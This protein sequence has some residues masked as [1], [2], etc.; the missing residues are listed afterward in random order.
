[1]EAGAAS[2]AATPLPTIDMSTAVPAQVTS[3]LLGRDQMDTMAQ[4]SEQRLFSAPQVMTVPPPDHCPMEVTVQTPRSP[5]EPGTSTASK[6]LPDPPSQDGKN[7]AVPPGGKRPRTNPRPPESMSS[8]SSYKMIIKPKCNFDMSRLP[9]RIIQ[10]T[11]EAYLHVSEFKG[12]ALHRPT[13]TISVWV[14]SMEDVSLLQS[15]QTIEVSKDLTVPVQAYLSSGTDLRRYVVSGVDAG[16]DPA[17]LLQ[18]LKFSTH[19]V[20][21]ARHLGK[22]RSCLVTLS[23]ASDSP[24][25]MYYYG[26]ILHVRQYRP[27]AVYCY[28]CLRPGHMKASCPYTAAEVAETTTSQFTCGLCKTNDHQITSPLCP[29]KRKLQ[30]RCDNA[31][32]YNSLLH[33]TSRMS[34]QLKYQL[35]RSTVDRHYRR[36]IV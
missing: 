11:L 16:E 29:T 10:R 8:Q 3:P 27:S 23:G 4:S 19:R 6:R 14:H 34:P 9:N 1:M 30:S 17:T 28:K 5:S 21:A 20:V 22:G 32:P 25:R 31:R 12:F 36:T 24:P 13:N 7:I 35:L 18:D 2:T 26:C 33:V 15:L